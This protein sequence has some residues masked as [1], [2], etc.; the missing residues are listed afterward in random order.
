M[1]KLIERVISSPWFFLV[2]LVAAVTAFSAEYYL[3]T[4]GLLPQDP[5]AD[6]TP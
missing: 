1:D 2:L 5:Y 4:H 3:A 6:P